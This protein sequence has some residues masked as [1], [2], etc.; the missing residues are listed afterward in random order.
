MFDGAAEGFVVT[1]TLSDSFFNIEGF[2]GYLPT[3]SSIYVVFRGTD[4]Y[5]VRNI[6]TDMDSIQ[7]NYSEIPECNC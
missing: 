5:S 3:N 2:I 1:K 7:S 6:L 4:M